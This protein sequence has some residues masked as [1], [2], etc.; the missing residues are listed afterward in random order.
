MDLEGGQTLTT[1]AI[2]SSSSQV[3]MV[4]SSYSLI[5]GLG[6]AVIS[7]RNPNFLGPKS[8]HNRQEITPANA[9]LAPVFCGKQRLSNV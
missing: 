9:G 6:G 7:K 8:L 3:S 5:Q 4:L 2:D 1:D